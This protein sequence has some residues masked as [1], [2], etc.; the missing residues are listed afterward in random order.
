MSQG[1]PAFT[2]LERKSLARRCVS[3]GFHS[4]RHP[5]RTHVHELSPYY[6]IKEEAGREYTSRKP[7]SAGTSYRQHTTRKRPQTI[8]FSG[9]PGHYHKTTNCKLRRKQ[10]GSGFREGAVQAVLLTGVEKAIVC[11]RLAYSE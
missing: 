7:Q 5:E 9:F 3:A 1:G 10:H 8:T 6:D 2:A 4:Q 11:T